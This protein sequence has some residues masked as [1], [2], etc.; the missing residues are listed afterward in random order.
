M[1]DPLPPPDER[2]IESLYTTGYWLYSDLRIEKAMPVF[3]A[4]IHIA[5][6]DERGWLALG[7]CHEIHAQRDI[8]R[9]VYAAGVVVAGNAPLCADALKRLG[10][11]S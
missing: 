6:N 10:A 3:R 11:S 4:M 8:A 1:A 7:A 9:E 5:P 2:L